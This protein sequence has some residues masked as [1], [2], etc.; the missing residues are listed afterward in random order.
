MQLK[1]IVLVVLLLLAVATA[2]SADK[3]LTYKTLLLADIS[4]LDVDRRASATIVTATYT[5]KDSTGAIAKSGVVSVTLS[6]GQQNTL[7]TFVTSVV[8]PA[9]NTQ[10]GL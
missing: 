9:A 3:T 1:R 6:G 7:E 2:A 5:V 8:L 10:E 4:R